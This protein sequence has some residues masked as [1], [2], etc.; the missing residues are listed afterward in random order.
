MTGSME[1]E[2]TPEML[3]VQNEYGSSHGYQIERALAAPDVSSKC[4]H[5]LIYFRLISCKA[6]P[7][8]SLVSGTHLAKLR[9]GGQFSG[10]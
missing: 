8:Q 5:Y 1:F 10:L 7:S 3:A 6:T 4:G 9:A 2:K